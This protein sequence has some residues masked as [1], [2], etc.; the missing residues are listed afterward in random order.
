MTP[1]VARGVR[2]VVLVAF[3][4]FFFESKLELLFPP[5]VSFSLFGNLLGVIVSL[6]LSLLSSELF[7]RFKILKF[8]V[9]FVVLIEAFE[10]IIVVVVNC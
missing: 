9:P 5:S 4:V 10:A 2:L 6:T 3:A 7:A 1:I 8:A